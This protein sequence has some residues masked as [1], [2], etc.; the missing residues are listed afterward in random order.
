MI[1]LLFVILPHSCA[2]DW[3]GPAEAFRIA[4]Q[5][6]ERQGKSAAF[7]MRFVGPQVLNGGGATDAT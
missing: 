1:D 5:T 7:K 4:N 3:A 6:L 2:L